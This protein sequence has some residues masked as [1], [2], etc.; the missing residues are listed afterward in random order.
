MYTSRENKPEWVVSI[1]KEVFQD[2][3]KVLDIGC[4]QKQLKKILSTDVNYIGVDISGT[5]DVLFN[6]DKEENLPFEDKSYDLVFCSEVLE[7]LENIHF[8]FDELCRLSKKYI[9]ISLPNPLSGVF[10]Y[11]FRKKYSN[12]TEKQKEFGEFIKFYGLPID[13]PKDRHRWFFNT[14]EALEFVSKRAEKNNYKIE[15]VLYTIDFQRGI[16]KVIK[17]ML[18]GF[19]RKRMLNLFNG[20]TWFMIRKK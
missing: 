5:P 14:E 12:T 7:H 3:K 19:S 1:F 11:Y 20:T 18:S 16:R 6:F 17:I 15:K 9:I 2:V 10:A 13:K 4:D 8:I